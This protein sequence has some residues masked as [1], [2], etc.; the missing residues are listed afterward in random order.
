MNVQL[1][2]SPIHGESIKIT[3]STDENCMETE[4][5]G[6]GGVLLCN[7]ALL[8]PSVELG[9]ESMAFQRCE[10]VSICEYSPL[11]DL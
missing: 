4:G 11:C 7:L 3:E 6:S 10:P 8:K 1:T 5:M 2:R 9:T